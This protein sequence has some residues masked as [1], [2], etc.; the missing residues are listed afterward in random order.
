[1]FSIYSTLSLVPSL[2]VTSVG[3]GG[4][5]GLTQYIMVASFVMWHD[6]PLPSIQI[7]L[8]LLFLECVANARGGKLLVSGLCTLA[9][10][11]LVELLYRIPFEDKI[12]PGGQNWVIT[13]CW[14]VEEFHH[15]SEGTSLRSR[16]R[17][18]LLSVV[19]FRKRR[20]ISRRIRRVISVSGAFNDWGGW[21]GCHKF[22]PVFGGGGTKVV[23]PGD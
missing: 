19:S 17:G 12:P 22:D 13:A 11:F 18:H 9:E 2:V 14:L 23:P 15:E 20:V 7:S 8:L 3:L 21:R 10:T 5:G 1:M 4:G 6:A 16:R